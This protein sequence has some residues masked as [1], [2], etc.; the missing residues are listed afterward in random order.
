M[1]DDS[2][3]L[4]PICDYTKQAT[5]G[6]VE[7]LRQQVKEV[8]NLID[9]EFS[10]VDEERRKQF[11]S[12]IHS[13]L[14]IT[15]K[16]RDIGCTLCAFG[17]TLRIEK[18]ERTEEFITTLEDIIRQLDNLQ[19]QFS[20]LNNEFNETRE[21]IENDLIKAR[22]IM[23]IAIISAVIGVGIIITVITFGIGELVACPFL[24]ALLCSMGLTE[25]GALLGVCGAVGLAGLS[26]FGLGAT[27]AHSSRMTKEELLEL[28]KLLKLFAN[29][30]A[31]VRKMVFNSQSKLLLTKGVKKP[32]DDIDRC[33]DTLEQAGQMLVEAAHN[34]TN[35]LYDIEARLVS[36]PSTSSCVLI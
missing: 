35:N 33:A 10:R 26:L 17:K 18:P 3:P 9:Q 32:L 1:S 15:I 7:S 31:N 34:A 25:T 14:D 12:L 29:E 16:A 36:A 11:R 8:E 30:T 4:A 27:R 13:F 24:C 21:G 22:C 23:I 28:Q 6:I 19:V 5:D 20:A 2:F